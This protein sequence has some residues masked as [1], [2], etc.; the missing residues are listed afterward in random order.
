[1]AGELSHGRSRG[2]QGQGGAAIVEMAL[3]SPFL[4]MLLFGIV[5]SSWLIARSIDVSSAAREAGRMAGVN[6]GGSP[7]IAASVCAGMDDSSGATISFAGAG[8]GLGGDV[9][10]TVTQGVPT[11]TG[12]L[13]PFFSPPVQLTRTTTF[14]LEVPTPAWT[15]GV[16][17]CP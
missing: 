3:L 12:L 5:E 6:E 16:Q 13:D 2:N 17:S 14:H 9:T 8:N 10:V 15:N 4:V 1:M 7:A 11:L